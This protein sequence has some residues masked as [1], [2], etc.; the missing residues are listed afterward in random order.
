MLGLYLEDLEEG[1][2]VELGSYR[3]ERAR[4][5][6]FARDYDPQDFHL[7]DEAAKRGPF[8]ALSAS[9]WHTAAG[10]MKCFVASNQ[11]AEEKLRAA[12][13]PVV[14]V[15]PSPGFTELKW[16]KPV[17]VGDTVTYSTRV[18]GR[19]ELKSRPE[20]GLLLS[21]NEGVNQNGELVFSFEGKV[22]TRRRG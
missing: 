18:T 14:E 5:I 1:M 2:K 4:M 3:F 17:F 7:D 20:W 16:P 6:A 8:G 13:K 10:W 22:M 19:R 9:G 15:G 12:G 21:H 11:A